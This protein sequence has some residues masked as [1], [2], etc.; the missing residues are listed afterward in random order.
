MATQSLLVPPLFS[1]SSAPLYERFR[2]RAWGDVVGQDKVVE[3]LKQLGARS[4]LAGRAYWLAGGSGTGKTTIARLIAAQVAEEMNVEEIDASEA[5]PARL[6]DIERTSAVF[7]FGEKPGRAFLLNEAH[8]L[9][10]SAVRQ[11][12]VLLERIPSHVVW[13]FTTTTEGQENL[14]EDCIDASPLLSRCIRLDLARR[15]LAEAFAARAQAIAQRENLDGRPLKDY[16]RLVQDCHNNFRAVL[17][18][19]ESGAMMAA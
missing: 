15:G 7:A 1:P 5:T 4:G 6:K 18:E 3:R 19:V 11:L 17:Q 13:A 2:P 14:F 12:L 9:S 10:K 8:G 16:L